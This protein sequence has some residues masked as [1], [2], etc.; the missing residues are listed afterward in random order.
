[1]SSTS[2]WTVP[3]PTAT[4]TLTDV[5]AAAYLRLLVRASWTMR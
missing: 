1:V 2:T 4:R 3:E 5:S